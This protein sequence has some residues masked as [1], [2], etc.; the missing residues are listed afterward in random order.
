ME[1]M[2][3]D[4]QEQA[5]SL[6]D[7]DLDSAI[8]EL[9]VDRYIIDTTISCPYEN[10]IGIDP[11]PI[12]MGV[13][14]IVIRNKKTIYVNRDEL[15]ASKE[16][17]TIEELMRRLGEFMVSK[18]KEGFFDNSFIVIERQWNQIE[19]QAILWAFIAKFY[20]RILVIG[21]NDL[22]MKYP[23][24]FLRVDDKSGKD[25]Y[26][27]NKAMAVYYGEKFL[28][29]SNPLIRLPQ[30]GRATDFYDALFIAI[31]G[32]FKKFGIEIDMK[33]PQNN[34]DL[35]SNNRSDTRDER[36]NFIMDKP[37]QIVAGIVNRKRRKTKSKDDEK[38]EK[39]TKKRKTKKRDDEKEEKATKKRKAKSKSDKEEEEGERET[40]KRKTKKKDDSNQKEAPAKKAVKRPRKGKNDDLDEPEE[41][42][43]QKK[44]KKAKTTREKSKS[45][46]D[47]WMSEAEKDD[48]DDQESVIEEIK[49]RRKEKEQGK[50]PAP[51]KKKGMTERSTKPKISLT[52][53]PD[54]E[55]YIIIPEELD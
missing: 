5:I 13:C 34:F 4:E 18:E 39:A 45:L 29:L 38:E 8:L 19:N 51:T 27:V 48:S 24:I 26:L 14:K 32:L 53:G 12:N 11:G 50:K 31:Y 30:K 2:C 1:A 52:G 15:R 54:D 25:Q 42:E 6:L 55:G 41:G 47:R 17:I 9:D 20:D 23:D 44:T 28:K 46:L 49:R 10:V 21:A 33:N 7:D 16:G 22:K 37:T 3:S 43:D 40:K 35:P 36:W